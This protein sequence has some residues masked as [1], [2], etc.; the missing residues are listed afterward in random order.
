MSE[1]QEIENR[2]AS[3]IS[4]HLLGTIDP[5]DQEELS[6]WLEQEGNWA[7]YAKVRQTILSDQH[8]REYD[9]IDAEI[10]WKRLENEIGGGKMFVFKQVIRIA[11]A[12]LLPLM[13]GLLVYLFY[14]DTSDVTIIVKNEVRPGHSKAIL[15]M[16]NGEIIDLE[17]TNKK[18]I[19]QSQGDVVGVDSS[20]ILSYKLASATDKL[21]YNTIRTPRG[22]EYQVELS[23]GTRVWLNAESKLR[24]PVNFIGETREVELEGEAIFEVTKNKEKPFRVHTIEGVVE[25]LGTTFNVSSYS[26]DESEEITLVEGS[27]LVESGHERNIL[28][29]GEQLEYTKV[30]QAIVLKKVDTNIYTA[31][32]DGIFVFD[33]ENLENIMRKIARWYDVD[34]VFENAKARDIVF[35]GNLPRYSNWS[36]L[37]K[38]IESGSEVYFKEEGK[39]IYVE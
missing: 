13:I 11:A 25:V 35:K 31:W 16:E 20:N 19:R 9:S 28:K 10:G 2:I 26:D 21:I 23:D 17:N 37:S 27:V 12:V 39:T 38:I 29:P 32:R 34:I 15:E 18:F 24:Y 1:K 14:I 3:L 36:D 33:E 6:K 4:Q 8:K 30:S 5:E 7:V 22:G